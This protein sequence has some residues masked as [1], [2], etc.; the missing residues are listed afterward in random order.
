MRWVLS[1]VT[2][3]MRY[4]PQQLHTMPGSFLG[5]GTQFADL[6]GLGF[7]TTLVLI[8]GRRTMRRPVR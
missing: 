6:R 7:D 1:T 4:V 8:N 3:L 5:D 2:D